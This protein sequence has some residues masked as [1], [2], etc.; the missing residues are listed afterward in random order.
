MRRVTAKGAL[1]FHPTRRVMIANECRVVLGTSWKWV[2]RSRVVCLDFLER[3]LPTHPTP[4]IH[5]LRA[6]NR[7]E[8]VLPVNEWQRLNG[9]EL[10]P[11][12]N[13][14]RHFSH[15]VLDS[16]IRQRG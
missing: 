14:P 12:L 3:S 15:H 2:N 5:L 4:Q 10:R 8:L 11:N 13:Q 1:G 6:V 9:P 7:F 16:T